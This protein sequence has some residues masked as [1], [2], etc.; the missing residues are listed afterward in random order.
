M[1]AGCLT[2]APREPHCFL[3]PGWQ[4]GGLSIPGVPIKSVDQQKFFRALAA[5]LTKSGELKVPQWVDTVKLAKHKEPAPCDKNW[6]Y[7]QAVSTAWYL[8]LQGSAGVSF[9]ANIYG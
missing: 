4:H 1:K 6:F 9:V 8:H 7:A 2:C 5:F 3:P